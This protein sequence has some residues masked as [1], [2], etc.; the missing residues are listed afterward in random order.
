MKNILVFTLWSLVLSLLL[1]GCITL[2]SSKK[3]DEIAE[4]RSSVGEEL[5]ELKEDINSLSGKR[6]ELQYKMEKLQ[7]KQSQQSNELNT[8]LK[9]WRKDIQGNVEK[10]IAN[11]NTRIRSI[12]KKQKQDKKEL[13]GRMK[14][15]LE[16]VTKEN[17]ELRR[18]IRALRK[19][20]N[21]NTEEDYYTIS[22]GD[23]LSQIS[24]IFGVSIKSIMKANNIANPNSIR[25]GQKLIIPQKS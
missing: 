6:D 16:E 23:T 3:R 22:A 21:A 12:E 20:L 1:N 11:I 10:K 15:I 4:I 24:D 9:G 8:T 7:Q 25:I 18:Q 17:T 19:S 5:I 13:K 14:I 2:D